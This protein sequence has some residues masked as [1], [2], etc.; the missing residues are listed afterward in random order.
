MPIIQCQITHAKTVANYPQFDN[1]K[2]PIL[3]T[4]Q[5]STMPNYQKL[6]EMLI[7]QGAKLPKLKVTEIVK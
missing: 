1:T 5:L 4:G 7:I 3:K 6:N 2:L